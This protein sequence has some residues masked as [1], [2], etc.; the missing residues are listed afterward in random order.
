MKVGNGKIDYKYWG[1]PEDM[2]M[3]RLAY[4]IDTTK[5]G[6]D[7]AAE[8]AAVMDAGLIVFRSSN[9]TYADVLLKHAK[10]FYQF[11]DQFRGIFSDSIIST[12]A[13]NTYQSSDYQDELVWGAAWL[14]KAT[15]D[16]LYL[17]KADQYF[18]LHSIGYP[19]WSFSWDEKTA[20]VQM[21]HY[22][23]TNKNVYKTA[24]EMSLN[25]WL[26][27][28]SVNYTPKGLAWCSQ[29]ASYRYAANTA[30]SALLAADKGLR[31][32][33][34]RQFGEKQIHYIC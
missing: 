34:Y 31:S 26:P 13:R 23:L 19:A 22:D 10:E 12:D 20:G 18:S 29:W 25:A 33:V 30:F 24:I 9:R 6:S 32:S 15:R 16:D 8:T 28:G 11:G 21:L 4:K 27:D 1:R 3:T 2:T 14:Y 5:P 7:L 17:Q